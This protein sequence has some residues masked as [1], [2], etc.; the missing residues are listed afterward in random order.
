M[1]FLVNRIQQLLKKHRTLH[2]VLYRFLLPLYL[3]LAVGFIG[4][5]P[6]PGF[7]E[8]QIG[9][10]LPAIVA[11]ESHLFYPRIKPKR[12]KHGV[13]QHQTQ[14]HLHPSLAFRHIKIPANHQPLQAYIVLLTV[15]HRGPPAVYG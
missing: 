15:L 7:A 10:K 3:I 12:L 8:E 6:N 11:L 5:L 14:N 2:P 4:S 13:E 9:T 1:Y